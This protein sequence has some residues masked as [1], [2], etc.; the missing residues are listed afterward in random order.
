MRKRVV[1]ALLGLVLFAASGCDTVKPYVKSTKRVYKQYVNVDPTIDLTDTG[2]SDPSLRKLAALFAPVDEKLE[3]MLRALS[4]QDL[5]PTRDWAQNFLNTFPWVSGVTVLDDTGKVV[6]RL[7]PYSLKTVDYEPLMGLEKLY[8][9]RKMGAAISSSEL[10]A[11]VLV[12]KPL[13]VDSDYKGIL[14]VQF[15]PGSLARYS[16]EPGQLIMVAPGAVLWAGDDPGAAQSLAQQSWKSILKGNVA[17]EM[18]LG[19]RY[20]WQ[21]RY[22]GQERIV[23]AVSEAP[24]PQKQAKAAKADPKPIDPQPTTEP[25][26]AQ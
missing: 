20:F 9:A 5:P 6:S 25:G 8:K 21:S 7:A 18:R 14:V 16:P 17:G 2:V 15:D 12:G 3:F 13:F 10:G 19:T 1:L 4:S 26:K 23:Y 11:D 24:A 22:I